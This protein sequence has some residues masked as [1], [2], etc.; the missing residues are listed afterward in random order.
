[1]SWDQETGAPSWESATRNSR[2]LSCGYA[3][4]V[5]L[6]CVEDT[7]YWIYVGQCPEDSVWNYVRGHVTTAGGGTQVAEVA[8]ASTPLPPNRSGQTLTC[9]YA[10]GNVSDLKSSAV[11]FANN[12]AAALTIRR[13]TPVWLGFR[14]KHTTGAEPTLRATALDVGQGAMLQTAAAGV[15]TTGATYAGVTSASAAT[16]QAIWLSLTRD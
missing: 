2:I 5:T 4:Q 13:N 6:L 9:L 8:I 11:T 7:A 10:S 1:M 14:S 12:V 16:A 15:L 3:S